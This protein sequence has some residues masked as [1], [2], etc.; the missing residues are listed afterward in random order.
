[1][2]RVMETV[3]CF[4][5]GF[6]C[7]QSILSTYGTEFGIDRD[8]ALKLATGFGGGM[9]RMAET[10]GAVTGALM[11][12]GLKYGKCNPG[13]DDKRE[14]TYELVKEFRR[15]FEDTNGTVVCRNLLNCDISTESGL[16]RA[17]DTGLFKTVCPKMVSD[18]A[19]I[20]EDMLL[21]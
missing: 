3:A 8:I 17:R 12:I 1:M 21:D 5:S 19:E 9:G 2:S 7:S 16:I 11:V 10:C 4:N 15:R 6:N 13:D 20:L 14:K 18:S